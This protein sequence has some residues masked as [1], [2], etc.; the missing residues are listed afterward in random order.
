LED[1][2]FT[3]RGNVASN[4]AVN[5][6]DPQRNQQFYNY[7]G[8][9]ETTIFLPWNLSLQSDI[10]YFANSG[11]SDGF[12]LNEWLWNVSVQKANLFKNNRGSVRLVMNDILQQRT[13]ISRIVAANYIRDTTTNTLTSY[14]MVHFI[15]RFDIFKGDITR[16]D[17]LRRDN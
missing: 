1:I 8:G 7:G 2:S 9:G 12:Q 10:N 11:Y 6:L 16:G 4:R 17:M 3:I 5:S 14:F 13:N 15:Y